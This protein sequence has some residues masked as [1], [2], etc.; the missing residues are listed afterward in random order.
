MAKK[1]TGGKKKKTTK[2][3]NKTP[4]HDIDLSDEY[5]S[6][7]Q[8]QILGDL[9]QPN[10]TFPSGWFKAHEVICV[11]HLVLKSVPN[12][13]LKVISEIDESVFGSILGHARRIYVELFYIYFA[14]EYSEQR[15]TYIQD[16][17]W[18][19][20]I[21]TKCMDHAFETVKSLIQLSSYE[22]AILTKFSSSTEPKS[23]LE[24]AP[25]DAKI[26][27][28]LNET[29]LPNIPSFVS[30]LKDCLTDPKLK[31]SG[32]SR[33]ILEPEGFSKITSLTYGDNWVRPLRAHS[34]IQYL[35][36]LIRYLKPHEAKAFLNTVLF[37]LMESSQKKYE[38]QTES[39]SPFSLINLIENCLNK[40]V[41]RDFLL[42][43][44]KKGH[45]NNANINVPSETSE[46]SKLEGSNFT[47]IKPDDY[48]RSIQ[49]VDDIEL[50]SRIKLLR[51]ETEFLLNQCVEFTSNSKP[52]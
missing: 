33:K 7:R 51:T 3:K 28:L 40:S 14:D 29:V 36:Q 8:E 19:T 16:S 44:E 13:S 20:T 50:W 37:S 34:E 4:S 26:S 49:L 35:R 18:A 10:N 23:L 17:A 12:R 9:A 25:D 15:L 30:S 39:A 11:E 38:Q 24:V 6:T 42:T 21:V 41:S 48:V 43:M 2:S 22:L 32:S 31:E 52:S 5:S 47:P 46:L 27:S 1:K 45:E